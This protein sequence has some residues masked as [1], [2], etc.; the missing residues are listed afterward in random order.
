MINIPLEQGLK[1]LYIIASQSLKDC[2]DQHSIRTRIET[3]NGEPG[4]IFLDTVM[5]NIPLEQGLKPS[6][7]FLPNLSSI[8]Y[9]QHSI[10]TRIETISI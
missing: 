1:L 6:S 10:R 5:I 8:C 3:K 7:I 2:Y 9:D 4:A